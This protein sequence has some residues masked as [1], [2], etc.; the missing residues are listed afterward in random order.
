MKRLL[1]IVSLFL[2]TSGCNHYKELEKKEVADLQTHL[3]KKVEGVSEIQVSFLRPTVHIDVHMEKDP[4]KEDI[5]TIKDYLTKFASRV[6][7]TSTSQNASWEGDIWNIALQINSPKTL[8]GEPL[9]F[10]SNY[11]LDKE[12]KVPD[13]YKKWT[14]IK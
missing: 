4:S 11:Y 3:S 8:K 9:A 5:Q 7:V 13:D 6:G 10:T 1:L 14:R 12:T 2:V